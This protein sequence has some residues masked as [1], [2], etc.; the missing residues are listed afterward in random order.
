M[1]ARNSLKLAVLL[2]IVQE[3]LELELHVPK[4]S[5]KTLGLELR[6]V[7]HVCLPLN[8]SHSCGLHTKYCSRVLSAC[9]TLSITILQV[10]YILN[11]VLMVCVALNCGVY[12]V[13]SVCPPLSI[14]ILQMVYILKLRTKT[15]PLSLF[16]P[17]WFLYG[18]I[19]SM[20]SNVHKTKERYST[21]IYI[22][23]L[24]YH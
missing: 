2:Y 4:S 5:W 16:S 21:T 1:D 9:P 10:A 8:C 7:C 12:N 6:T 23:I 14:V 24:Q 11:I 18:E 19:T 15:N 20:R 22:N 17:L 3:V 13:L